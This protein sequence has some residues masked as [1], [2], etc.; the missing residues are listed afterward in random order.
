MSALAKKTIMHLSKKYG[1]AAVEKFGKPGNPLDVAG[2]KVGITF[3]P[4]RRVINTSSAHQIMEYL[5]SNG[6]GAEKQDELMDLFFKRYFEEAEDLSKVERLLECVETVGLDKVEIEKMLEEGN[7]ESVMAKDE[8]YKRGGV[9]GV[10]FFFIGGYKFSGAQPP[11]VF[12]EILNEI[13][14]EE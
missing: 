1:P 13:I 7:G 2:S 12:E 8:K 3:N 4:S 9:S 5:K 6:T 10:P 11:E 14:E